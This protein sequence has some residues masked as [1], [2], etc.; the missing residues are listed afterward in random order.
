MYPNEMI[1][2]DNITLV[3]YRVHTTCIITYSQ[4]YIAN[5]KYGCDNDGIISKGVDATQ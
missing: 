3:Q 4:F 5:T 1:F 2:G